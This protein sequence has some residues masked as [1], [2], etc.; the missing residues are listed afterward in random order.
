[1]FLSLVFIVLC[2]FLL[3]NALGIIVGG[4]FWGLFWAI[5]FL[6]LG[7]KLLVRRGKCPVCGWHHWE[8]R[9]HEKIHEKMHGHC[10]DNHGEEGEDV[11]KQ[12]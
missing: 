1:M 11:R 8:G 12:K 6:A 4:N 10:C 9:M 5:V 3:L 7:L 2:L